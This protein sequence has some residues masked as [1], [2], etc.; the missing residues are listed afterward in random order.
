[1]GKR[2]Q[3]QISVAGELAC[4]RE[5][6]F[7]SV[8]RLAKMLAASEGGH[9]AVSDSVSMQ[10]SQPVPGN[11]QFDNLRELSQPVMV[12]REPA[13]DR[14]VDVYLAELGRDLAQRRA[15]CPLSSKYKLA[16]FKA[17]SAF[18]ANRSS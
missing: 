7:D 9:V 6:D 5:L 2:Y 1:M 13:G 17:Q 12:Q 11:Q 18:W 15:N 16:S 4:N 14:V 10:L 8:I 3:L